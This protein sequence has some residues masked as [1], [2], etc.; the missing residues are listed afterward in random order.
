[1]N[2]HIAKAGRFDDQ[3]AAESRYFKDE[4]GKEMNMNGM[5]FSRVA[6]LVLA[7]GLLGVGGCA[8]THVAIAKR[9]LDVQ[10]KMSATVFLDPV[11]PERRTV[12]VQVRNTSDRPDFDLQRPITE[13][14]TAKGYTVVEDATA[15]TYVLQAN[16]LQVGKNAP[17]AAEAALHQGYGGLGAI[18][19]G[20][21][22]AYA[23]SGS[24]RGIAG[25]GVLG[26]VADLV[27]GA[28]V[29][30]VYYSVIADIQIKERNA[31]GKTSGMTAQSTL[32]QGTASEIQVSYDETVDW[33]AYQTRVVSTANK[34][35]LEFDEAAPALQKGLTQSISGLF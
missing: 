19:M 2:G 33:R 34:M 13:A 17:T 3:V 27:A 22:A 11:A 9:D 6:T 26:G 29:K 12:F 8:A 10:T 32:K 14:V 16:V 23:L 25:A 5:I 21:G 20:T 1:M 18:V 15:A 30:D 35:N 4:G 24:G 31:A 28:A 7:V